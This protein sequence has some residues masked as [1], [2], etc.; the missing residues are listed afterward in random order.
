MGQY[1]RGLPL[2][3]MGVLTV[4]GFSAGVPVW[5]AGIGMVLVVGGFLLHRLVRPAKVTTTE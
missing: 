3:G 1:G 5:I 2:T 4:G